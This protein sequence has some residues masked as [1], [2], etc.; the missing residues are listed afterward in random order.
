MLEQFPQTAMSK[1]PDH[2]NSVPRIGT[3]CNGRSAGGIRLIGRRDL[4]RRTLLTIHQ[5]IQVP[6]APDWFVHVVVSEPVVVILR[7]SV[8][9]EACLAKAHWR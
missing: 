3:D 5:K 1:S 8:V 7:Y 2:F 6:I 4:E 9:I